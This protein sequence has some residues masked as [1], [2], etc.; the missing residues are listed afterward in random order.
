MRYGRIKYKNKAEDSN[1]GQRSWVRR[2]KLI[3]WKYIARVCKWR[4]L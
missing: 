4:E 3:L 2:S 1:K